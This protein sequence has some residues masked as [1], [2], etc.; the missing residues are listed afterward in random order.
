MITWFGRYLV[1]PDGRLEWCEGVECKDRSHA[2]MIAK[3][4]LVYH[5]V[6]EC[7]VAGVVPGDA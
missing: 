3:V 7:L 6:G 5:L 2:E 4:P 1:M